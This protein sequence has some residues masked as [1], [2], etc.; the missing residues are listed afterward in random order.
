MLFHVT[1][2]LQDFSL[3][4]VVSLW[5]VKKSHKQTRFPLSDGN[6]NLYLDWLLDSF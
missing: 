3:V 4:S 1:P 5:G 6:V 2:C